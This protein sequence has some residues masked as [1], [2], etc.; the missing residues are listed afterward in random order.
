MLYK[1]K[2]D[3]SIVK[4]KPDYFIKTDET[5]YFQINHLKEGNYKLVSILDA[6]NNYLYEPDELIAF[7]D[8]IINVKD[9]STIY[10][11]LL[12]K[13]STEKINYEKQVVL[14]PEK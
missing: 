13:G 8:T 2:D 1:S 11:L 3:S 6:S 12:F 4:H 5:G 10:Q 9:T 7:S 14:V